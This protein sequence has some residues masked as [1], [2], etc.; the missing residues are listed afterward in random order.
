MSRNDSIEVLNEA[1]ST[2]SRIDNVLAG[3]NLEYDWSPDIDW[4]PGDPLYPFP[5]YIGSGNVRGCYILPMFEVLDDR[6]SVTHFGVRVDGV[7]LAYCTDCEVGWYGGVARHT[8]CWS[9]ETP[10]PNNPSEE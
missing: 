1:D 8:V 10:K 7:T 2:T 9:C 5:R 6:L 3:V 4:W